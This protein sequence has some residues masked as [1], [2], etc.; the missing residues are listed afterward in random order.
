[1]LKRKI[2]GGIA[3]IILICS[4]SLKCPVCVVA[5]CSCSPALLIR[6]MKLSSR[7]S[8]QVLL[9]LVFNCDVQ[10]CISG[11]QAV[12]TFVWKLLECHFL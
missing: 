10:A 1:M 5:E 11:L 9:I 8:Q 7:C 2:S 12:V 6:S 4:I 3:G